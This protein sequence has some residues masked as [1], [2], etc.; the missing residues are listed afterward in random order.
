[1]CFCCSGHLANDRYRSGYHRRAGS[2][3]ERAVLLRKRG[4]DVA[5]NKSL[6]YAEA[7][8]APGQDRVPLSLSAMLTPEEKKQAL[9]E[10]DAAS[11]VH[12]RPAGIRRFGL[13]AW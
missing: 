12:H 1:M 5:E 9:A 13:D 10:E 2:A 3:H 8:L 7:I 6:T 11:F 4:I